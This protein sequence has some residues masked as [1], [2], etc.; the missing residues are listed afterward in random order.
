MARKFKK[1]SKKTVK[2]VR[3]KLEMIGDGN[4]VPVDY[5]NLRVLA[6]FLTEQGKIVPGRVSGVTRKQQ[7]DIVRSIKRARQL[8]LLPYTPRH[9]TAL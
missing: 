8:A 9:S 3:N 6:Q 1:R 5:K 4:D 2:R 7:A